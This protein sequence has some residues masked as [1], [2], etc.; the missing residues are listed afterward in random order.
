LRQRGSLNHDV[1]GRLIVRPTLLRLDRSFQIVCSLV[2]WDL[3][4]QPVDLAFAAR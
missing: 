3:G 4:S 2:D 1:Q